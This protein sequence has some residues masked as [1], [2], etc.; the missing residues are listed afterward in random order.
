MAKASRP[1]KLGE[2]SQ[3]HFEP[4]PTQTLDPKLAASLGLS[5][6]DDLGDFQSAG[7]SATVAAL[8]RL[9]EE[10]RPE[11]TGQTWTPHRPSRPDKSEG[12]IRFDMKSDFQ[13]SGDQPKAIAELSKQAR[14]NDRDQVLLGVTGSGKTFTMAKVI[15]E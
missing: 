10:G 14:A 2:R 3:R 4:A 11:V 5:V 12:G 1:G 9:I 7:A 8:S 13:P 15:E 6:G